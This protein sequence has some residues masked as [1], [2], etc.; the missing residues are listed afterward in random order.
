MPT[1]FTGAISGK[2]PFFLVLEALS[3]VL[4]FPPHKRLFQ[5]EKF[6]EIWVFEA[7]F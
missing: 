5:E 4:G 1:A 6:P 7:A 2:M 3:F